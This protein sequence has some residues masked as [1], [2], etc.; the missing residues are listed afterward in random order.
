MN[1]EASS[2]LA[3]QSTPNSSASEE[4][5]QCSAGTARPL[6]SCDL[7]RRRKVKC[8]RG[9]PCSS[10]RRA[11]VACVFS[12]PPRVPR[13]RKVGRR[14][15]DGEI[16]KRIAKLENLVKYLETENSGILSTALAINKTDAGY[17]SETAISA[18][19]SERQLEGL[20]ATRSSPNDHLDRYLSSSFWVT[21]SDEV[22]CLY[23]S[24]W[25]TCKALRCIS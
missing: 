4:Q 11:G 17:A 7:C 19:A 14:K 12:I 21:L 18:D 8:D 22:R 1:Q 2:T 3:Q 10:C 5:N 20:G 13:A 15:P 9:N 6:T 23:G 25:T 24:F 16:L